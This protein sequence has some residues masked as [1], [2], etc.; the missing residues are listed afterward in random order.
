MRRGKVKRI[1]IIAVILGLLSGGIYYYIGHKPNMQV[2]DFSEELY[3]IIEDILVDYGEPAIYDGKQLYISYDFLKKYV[4]EDLFYDEIEKTVIFTNEN[5]VKYYVLND[6]H[7]KINSKT[8][9]IDTPIIENNNKIYIPTDLFKS[10]YSIE[11]NHHRNT[12]AIVI[13]YTDMYYLTGEVLSD[14]PI[15]RSDM[16][17]KAPILRSSIVKGDLLNIYGEY[18]K[19]LRVRTGDGIVGFIEKKDIRINHTKDIYKTE[20]IIKNNSMPGIQDKI[21]LTW[22]YTYSKVKNT[23]NIIPIE[24]LTVISPTW[25][26]ILDID[27]IEDKGNREYVRKYREMGYE[28]WPLL[29]NSFSP[30]LTH[31]ILKSASSRSKTID[32]ILS[33]Y[34]SY[35]FDGINID[36]ENVY[37]KDRDLLTQFVRELYP[38]FKEHNMTVTMDVTA[39]S[40]SENWSL[41]YDRERLH[42]SLDYMILMAYDQH[43]A[44]SP[45]AGSVAEYTWVEEGIKGILNQVPNN[46]LILAVPFFTRLWTVEDDKVQ[47]KALTMEGMNNF[48]QDNSIEV[49]W[50]E[51][52]GQYY[53]AV[54]KE[55]KEYK[56]WMEDEKSLDYKISL[57]HKY[58]LPGIASWRK[59]FE[60]EDIWSSISNSLN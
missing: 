57:V 3:I 49:L 6:Y 41:C 37:F 11:I 51:E 21:N 25:F 19:W 44:S 31:D 34:L 54:K 27:R 50:Q 10:D 47:S 48:I 26:S 30:E 28:I 45:I 5:F 58:N 43:W 40:T 2:M 59:G 60:S 8:Y 32:D 56:F 23:D 35:G 1:F 9:K 46:K 39:I 55:E 36:F 7:G 22:D 15:I 24:G 16:D 18:E 20:L 33:L 42:K 53:G 12:N 52:I 13:D 29:D 38:V 14:E 17:I 4:D